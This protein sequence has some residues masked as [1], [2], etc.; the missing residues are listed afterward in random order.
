MDFNRIFVP[1][2]SDWTPVS[3]NLSQSDSTIGAFRASRLL[4][5][6]GVPTSSSLTS[7]C[8]ICCCYSGSSSS[9]PATPTG[10]STYE[11]SLRYQR[12]LTATLGLV[13]HSFADG[14]AL[15]AAFGLGQLRLEFLLF[16]AIML[17]KVSN[18]GPFI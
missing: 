15:G 11:M 13:V 9:S 5:A 7:P 16:T 3:T 2:H 14:M 8:S 10:L 12:C 1:L 18:S 6:S 4:S 17:H